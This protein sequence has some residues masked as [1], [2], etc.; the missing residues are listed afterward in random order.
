MGTFYEYICLVQK[1]R[2]LNL[3]KDKLKNNER[4][5]FTRSSFYCESVFCT[6]YRNVYNFIPV[7]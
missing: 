5:T 4:T 1:V 2:L 7:K 6:D 3:D